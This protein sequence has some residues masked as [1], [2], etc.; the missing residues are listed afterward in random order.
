M[1][2]LGDRPDRLKKRYAMIEDGGKMINGLI[3]ENSELFSAN[4]D[5]TEWTAYKEYVDEMIVEGFFN[6]ILT[7]MEYLQSNMA[8]NVNP[9]FRYL[10]R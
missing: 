4:T 6:A 3:S 5:T 8:P 9:F 7:S 2:N 1:I 10:L